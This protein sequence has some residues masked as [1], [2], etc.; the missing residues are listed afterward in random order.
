MERR[1]IIDCMDWNSKKHDQSKDELLMV[2]V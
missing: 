1:F 2:C